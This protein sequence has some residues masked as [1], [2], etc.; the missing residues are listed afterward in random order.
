MQPGDTLDLQQVPNSGT[1]GDAVDFANVIVG[2]SAPAAGGGQRDIVDPSTGEVYATA[3]DSASEDVDRA[4]AA[5]SAAFTTWRRTT[6]AVRSAALLRIADAL[7]ACA[8]ELARLEVRN[9]GKPFAATLTEELGPTIDYVRFFAGACRVLEGRASTEYVDGIT[10]GIRR[11]PVGV[12]GQITPWNYPLMMAVWKWA[13]AVAAGNTVVLKPSELTPASTVRMAEIAQQHLPAGVLNVVCGGAEVGQAIVRHTQVAM[14]SF[15]GSVP[16][17]RAVARAAADRTI[18][19]H[20]ELGGNAPVLVF[21]DADLDDAADSIA[22]G[23]FFNAGQDCTAST[24]VLVEA[25]RHDDL[26][27]ALSERAGAMIPGPPDDPAAA[28]GPL[29]SARQLGKVMRLLEQVAPRVQIVAGG[30][31]LPRPG[32][33]LEATVLTGVI[34]SDTVVQEEIFGPVV[35]VQPF[36]TETDAVVMANGVEHGLTATVFTTNQARAQRLIRDLDFGAVSVNTHA[37]TTAEMPH[38]GFGGSGFGKDLSSYALDEYTRIKHV[39]QA[40]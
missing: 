6:P 17:G 39:A 28:F 38:G 7:E 27:E 9:T 26:V 40:M 32:Y 1:K 20:L 22:W 19:T 23:A 36:S 12:C 30:R 15:T 21:D 16:V 14:V 2:R 8:D 3:A 5:A 37:P 24:R 33:Y 35:T 34:Q 11:E 13:P 4:A 25:S 18:R 10:S 31:R 29:I